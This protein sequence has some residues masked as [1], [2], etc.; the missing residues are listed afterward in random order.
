MRILSEAGAL[1]SKTLRW[2][3]AAANCDVVLLGDYVDWRGEPLEG[4]HDEWPQGPRRVVEFILDLSLQQKDR[5]TRGRF[6]PLLGNHDAM[7]LEGYQI[8]EEFC[9]QEPG[10]LE[11]FEKPDALLHYFSGTRRNFEEEDKLM[12]FLNWYQQGG[13]ATIASFGGMRAWLGAMGGRIGDF[14]RNLPVAVVVNQKL[15]C[16][17]IPDSKEYWVRPDDRAAKSRE[18]YPQLREQYLWGRKVWGLDAFKGIKTRP[19]SEDEV[20]EMLA[21]LKVKAVVVGHTSLHQKSPYFHYGGKII[22]LDTHGVPGSQAFIE[23]Y[24]GAV[25][26]PRKR[27]RRT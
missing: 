6:H 21:K 15:F 9:R 24:A 13:D 22:N 10:L 20:D 12:R 17:S 8:L 11:R 4:P 2:T 14:L 3:D 23:E 1:D 7:M 18:D 19:L 26:V 16:H 5:R 25:P 27:A